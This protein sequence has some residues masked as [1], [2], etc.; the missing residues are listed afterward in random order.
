[1]E[2]IR[3]KHRELVEGVTD[4][5]QRL[6][7]ANC[8]LSPNDI[9]YPPHINPNIHD[10]ELEKLGYD[11]TAIEVVKQLPWLSN[12]IVWEDHGFNVAPNTR[13]LNYFVQPGDLHPFTHVDGICV[14]TTN[15]YRLPIFTLQRCSP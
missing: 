4:I 7:L 11:D 1:M 6:A 14:S 8:D 13:A 9:L 10:T 15:R 3:S 12:R 5:Y 2:N